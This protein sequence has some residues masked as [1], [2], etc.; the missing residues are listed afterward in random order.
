LA[1]ALEGDGW[2]EAVDGVNKFAGLR[3]GIEFILGPT[4]LKRRYVI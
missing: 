1:L 3:A 2:L 4:K